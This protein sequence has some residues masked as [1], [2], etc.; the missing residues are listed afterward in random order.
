M[1]EIFHLTVDMCG[2]HVFVCDTEGGL[3]ITE[4]IKALRECRLESVWHCQFTLMT[5]VYSRIAASLGFKGTC[6]EAVLL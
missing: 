4:L 1:N 6:D 2:L 3:H 5:C